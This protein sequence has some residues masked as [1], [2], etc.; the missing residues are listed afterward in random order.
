MEICRGMQGT[1]PAGLQWNTIIDLFLSYL[2][3]VKHVIEHD[4]YTLQTNSDNY[5]LVVRC[6]TDEFLCE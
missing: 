6:S 5:V 4:I 1:K 2:G 3:F